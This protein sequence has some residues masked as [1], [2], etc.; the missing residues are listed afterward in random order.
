MKKYKSLIIGTIIVGIGLLVVL[1]AD[2]FFSVIKKIFSALSPLFVGGLI[3]LVLNPLLKLFENKLFKNI[4]LNKGKKLKRPL[5]LLLSYILFFGIIFGV[6]FLVVPSFIR[7]INGF[8]ASLDDT[9]SKVMAGNNEILKKIIVSLAGADN[10]KIGVE[11]FVNKLTPS[12]MKITKGVI[13]GAI[14]VLLGTVI[15]IYILYNK[16]LLGRQTARVLHATLDEKK[17]RK[18]IK[19]A[20]I[21]GEKFSGFMSGQI[22]EALLLGVCCYLGMRAF[23]IPYASMV[24]VLI[25]VSNLIPIIGGYI[26]GVPS[27]IIIYMTNPVKAV[28][29]VIFICVLQQVE[30][31]TTYPKVVGKTVGLSGLWILIAVTVFGAL[32]GFWGVLFGVPVTAGLY[33]VFKTAIDMRLKEKTLDKSLTL[34]DINKKFD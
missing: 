29:F 6:V 13:K 1:N 34:S 12:L 16:E 27:A 22:L 5:A 18:F 33:K 4:L 32:F 9:L 2:V 7:S 15:S 19:L 20:G 24:S 28:I 30:A 14:N 10:I 17:E 23:N 31:I 11:N 25:G 3:A 21:F 8:V 26:S